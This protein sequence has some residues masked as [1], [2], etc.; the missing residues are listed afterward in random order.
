MKGDLAFYKA[1]PQRFKVG[2]NGSIYDIETGR[3]CDLIP[4]LNPHA[5]TKEN[6]RAMVERKRVIAQMGILRG[7]AKKAN[8]DIDN[9]TL[10]ELAQGA[11]TAIE[12]MTGHFYDVFMDSKN[13]RGMAEAYK[14]LISPMLGD[15]Q[16]EVQR[17]PEAIYLEAANQL[18]KVLHEIITPQAVEGKVIE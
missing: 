12:N 13:M 1:N 4:E 11:G 18:L 6:A 9:A 17:E 2:I 14:G 15:E 8:V 5:I 16:R 3:Y 10:E 7:L